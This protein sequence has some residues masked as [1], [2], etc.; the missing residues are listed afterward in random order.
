M[1][2]KTMQ[3]TPVQ[4][5]RENLRRVR[6]TR[7]A[8]W[9]QLVLLACLIAGP[10]VVPSFRAMDVMTKV[11]IF[12]VVAASYDL[13]LGYT[14]ILSLAHVTFFGIGAYSMA[15][16][17]FHSGQAAWY[18]IPVAMALAVG[19]SGVLAVALAFFSL[20]VKAIF[21]TMMSLA[22]A[23]FVFILGD[24]WHDLTMGEDG[25]SFSL[26]GIFSVNWS[27]GT[28]LGATLN[29]RLMTYYFI[30]AASVLLF[31]GLVRFVR[32]PVGRVL[33]SVRDNEQRSTALGY[34]T[35]HYKVLSN[36]FG[37]VVASLA[38]VLF[39]MWLGY[40]NPTSVLGIPV[41]LNIL[42]MV[43]I[44]GMGTLYGSIMGAAFIQVAEAWLPDLQKLTAWLLPHVEVAQRLAERWILYFGILFILVVIFF[45]K[46]LVGT[47]RD[48]IA[49]RKLRLAQRDHQPGL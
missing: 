49:R 9:V 30:L 26:P 39:A 6:F 5:E 17:V 28:F 44:G 15:L 47:A 45:P 34:K 8:L 24:Q 12:A 29:G 33:K 7:P 46:G 1:E 40:V 43:I 16:V 22:L 42:L 27:D 41:M 35:F 21:F 4:M 23:E 3:P 14:G 48:V 37:S 10:L 11:M 31:I 20:R 32:S 2:S 25:V 19:I 13:I 36:V 18:H 38:G